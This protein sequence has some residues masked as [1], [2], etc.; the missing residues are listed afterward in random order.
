VPSSGHVAG[1]YAQLDNEIGVH[2]RRPIRVLAW[3]EDV[4]A[5]VDDARHG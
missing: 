5:A 1:L 4:S 2:R 3:A